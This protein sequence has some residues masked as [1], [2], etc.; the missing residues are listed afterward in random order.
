MSRFRICPDSGFYFDRSAESL[1]KVN[2]VAAVVAL[3]I[4]G[5]PGRRFASRQRPYQTALRPPP[6][7]QAWDGIASPRRRTR[8]GLDRMHQ[9]E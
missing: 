4:A 8:H 1:M 7:S 9:I 3:L 6:S 5:L 2:A